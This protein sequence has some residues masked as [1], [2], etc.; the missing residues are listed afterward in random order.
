MYKGL[1]MTNQMISY[2]FSAVLFDMDGVVIDNTPLHQSVW[3]EFAQLHGLN[4]SKDVIRATNGR[5][6]VDVVLS[7]FGNIP[8]TQVV[9]LA[10]A[11]GVL[12]RQRFATTDIQPVSGVKSFLEKLGALGI[13]RVLAT[14]ARPDNVTLVLNRLQLLSYFENIVSASD[15]CNG[16]PDPEVYLTAAK[17][18]FVQPETCLV[19][20]DSLPG[21]KA[22]KAA[23]S[24]CLGMTTSQSEESLKQ[25]GADWVAPTFDDLPNQLQ[26]A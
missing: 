14:S 19:I 9:E 20:E 4:P 16:K 22:A 13:P 23:G 25:V 8:H 17:L 2:P 15:V 6:A 10:A 21:I 11:R 1:D 24:F 3:Q 12:Y 26:I 5:R 7:I 18:A